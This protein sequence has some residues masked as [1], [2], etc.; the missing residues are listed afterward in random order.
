MVISYQPEVRYQLNWKPEGGVLQT[1]CSEM[2]AGVL[3]TCI[4][5][6]REFQ[7]LRILT[8]PMGYCSHIPHWYV[9]SRYPI[10]LY[11]YINVETMHVEK[12]NKCSITGWQNIPNLI[13][14]HGIFCWYP[15]WK[16]NPHTFDWDHVLKC[17]V[18]T[19]WNTGIE[20]GH[21]ITSE[22]L[23]VGCHPEDIV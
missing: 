1:P 7:K 2:D 17:S 21:V 16:C 4:L 23:T 18:H 22:Y 13:S 10:R 3:Q 19:F 8:Y 5:D 20:S 9:F 6:T 14:T 11:K 15:T 12:P